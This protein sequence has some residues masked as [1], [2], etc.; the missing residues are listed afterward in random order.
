MMRALR[1]H[2]SIPRFALTRLAD[3]APGRTGPVRR[4]LM[5]ASL[6]LERLPRPRLPGKE[7][8]R[9]RPRLAGICGTDLAALAARSSP[10]LAPFSSFPAVM[11]HEVV[12]TVVEAPA[13]S[14]FRPGERVVVDPALGCRARGL[15]PCAACLKGRPYLCGRLTE[16]GLAPGMII[17]FC[18]DA[19]GGWAEEMVAH[20]SQLHRAPDGVSDEA[21][22]LAEP[23]AVGVHAVF[24]RPPGAGER[25]LIIGGGTIGLCVLAALRMTGIPLQ[26]VMAAR[27]P[28]QQRFAAELG[29]EAVRIV[30]PDR[31]E[32]ALAALEGL[33]GVRRHDP[34][35]GRPVFDGGFDLTYECAGSAQSLDDA[36]RAT[37]PGGTVVV[38]GAVSTAPAVDWTFVWAR[39]L[40]LVG[41]VGYGW[42]RFAGREGHTFQWALEH[43]AQNP[44]MGRLV[45]HKFPL[46]TYRQALRAAWD[47]ARSGAVKVCFEFP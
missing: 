10:A 15:E 6:R 23:L 19:P 13:E 40:N 45:T 4:G 18:R 39:E 3:M 9:L 22:V 12:A 37:R 1:H 26:I 28:V 34:P 17:G 41:A 21:A 29:G 5:E 11:G 25:V 2:L 14:G 35:L 47:R 46:E 24:R 20:P 44:R 36:L 7:W 38:A 33:A 43:L 31:K 32:G 27:H 30:K 16:G 8:V 42:E